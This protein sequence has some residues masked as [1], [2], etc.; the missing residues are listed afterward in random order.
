MTTSAELYDACAEAA[1]AGPS[2]RHS[3]PVL[4]LTSPVV[5]VGGRSWRARAAKPSAGSPAV[6]VHGYSARQCGQITAALIP[7][8]GA[9]SAAAEAHAAAL[10]RLGAPPAP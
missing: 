7:V 8:M 4:W 5:T 6:T 9:Q 1:Q 10:L 3:R 2:W